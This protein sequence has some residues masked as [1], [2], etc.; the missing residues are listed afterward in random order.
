MLMDRQ[1]NDWAVYEDIQTRMSALQ[2][3]LY[4]I[5]QADLDAAAGP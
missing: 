5:R 1:G 2:Q 4:Q 3:E